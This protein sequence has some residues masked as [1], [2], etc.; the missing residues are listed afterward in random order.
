MTDNL[1]GILAVLASSTTFVVSDA[2][3]KLI[4]ARLP[5]SEIIVVRGS[6][7]TVLLAL[8]ARLLGGWRPVSILLQ[9]MMLLR[10]LSAG[11]ASCLVVL[12]LR[13]LPLA[14]VNAV[15]QMTPLAVTAGAAI[16]YGERVGPSRW[17]A[18]LIGFVGVLLI[19]KPG[20][21]IFGAAAFTVLIALIFTTTRDL[22]TRGLSRDIP[23]MFVGAAS[24]CAISLSGLVI[25][26]FD[27]PW[28]MPGAKDWQ[29]MG[30]SA[31]LLFFGNTLLITALRTGEIGVVAPFRYAPVPLSLGLGYLWWGDVP[32]ALAVVGIVMVLSAGLALLFSERQSLRARK[33]KPPERTAH[34]PQ[35]QPDEGEDR[36]R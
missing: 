26:P 3:V 21:S 2:I 24:A 31:V 15:L 35:A 25:V 22:T 18:A 30:I 19:V 11:A 13:D 23:A 9:P 8:G 4:A 29:L 28:V 14:N 27:A 5:A 6:M 32:D 1:R 10:I 7:A 34:E 12:S 17:L 36:T 33:P 20:S 16:V